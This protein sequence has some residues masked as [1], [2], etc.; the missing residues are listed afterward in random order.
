MDPRSG[1]GDELT[2]GQVQNQYMPCSTE[3]GVGFLTMSPILTPGL[4]P[5]PV[6]YDGAHD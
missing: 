4:K 5:K 6:I 1:G 3:H 2:F